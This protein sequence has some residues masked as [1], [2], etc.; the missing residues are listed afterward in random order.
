MAWSRAQSQTT[1]LNLCLAKRLSHFVSALKVSNICLRQ[2]DAG[3]WRKQHGLAAV[4][5]LLDAKVT[6]LD[7]TVKI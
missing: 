1:Q 4:W 2:P 6:G 3:G 5:Q 7:V